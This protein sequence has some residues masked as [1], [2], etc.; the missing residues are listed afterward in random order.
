MKK[1]TNMQQVM[2]TIKHKGEFYQEIGGKKY[3]ISFVII[4][5]MKLLD[6]I[7]MINNGQLFYQSEF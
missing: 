1:V 5:G 2:D 7:T 3:E 6:I 4:L